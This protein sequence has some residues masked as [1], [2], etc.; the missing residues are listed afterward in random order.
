M[1]TTLGI[2]CDRRRSRSVE[3]LSYALYRLA[4]VQ[5]VMII[6]Y[7]FFPFLSFVRLLLLFYNESRN[8]IFPYYHLFLVLQI[9]AGIDFY[10]WYIIR[11]YHDV[12]EEILLAMAILTIFFALELISAVYLKNMMLTGLVRSYSSSRHFPSCSRSLF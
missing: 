11:T 3:S 4:I 9:V 10:S 6:P 5:I 2:L 1:F 8:R 12:Y 7:A